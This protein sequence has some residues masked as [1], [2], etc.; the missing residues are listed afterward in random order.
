M[1]RALSIWFPMLPIDLSR[2]RRLREPSPPDPEGCLLLIST[3]ARGQIVSHCCPLAAQHG[4]RPGLNITQARAILPPTLHV[5]IE[6]HDPARDARAL[7]ALSVVA[8]SLS[9]ITSAEAPDGILADV[10]GCAR[11]FGGEE[12][13]VR[14]AISRFT[15]LGFHVRA[16]IAPTYGCAQAVVRCGRS[17]IV[18]DGAQRQA[19]Y[20]LPIRALRLDPGTEEALHEV[21]LDTIGQVMAIPRSVLPARFGEDI[22]LRLDQ[23]LGHAM[24]TIDPI[25][26]TDPIR[27]DRLFDGPSDQ[28]EAI[29]LTVRDLLGDLCDHLRQRESGTTRFTLQLERSDTEPLNLRFALSAPARDAKHLWKLV[30]PRLEKANLGFGVEGISITST[31]TVR[32]AHRQNTCW[33]DGRSRERE[34][35]RHAWLD[36]MANRF[37]NRVKRAALVESHLPERAVRG[38]DISTDSHVHMATCRQERTDSDAAIWKCARVNIS[39]SRPS[40]L[41]PRPEPILITALAPDGPVLAF[42][43]RNEDER[44]VLCRGPERIEP[45]WWKARGD[46]GGGPRDYFRLQDTRGRWLWVY[47]D[48]TGWFVHGVWA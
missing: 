14:A 22:L 35:A 32:I 39:S 9:P 40:L 20:P 28:F 10:S 2:R 48:E 6:P 11:V 8:Q 3:A 30:H 27:V 25:H 1:K 29:T 19:L 23:A 4:V 7:S 37:G 26:T 41:F 18:P 44:V 31:R 33:G 17:R 16:A 21:G 13:L 38:D 45:E 46:S 5:R 15:D 47:R 43:W 34:S 12:G 36:T 24:E 42:R